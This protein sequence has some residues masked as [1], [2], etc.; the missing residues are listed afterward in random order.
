[1]Q[2]RLFLKH[3]VYTAGTLASLPLLHACGAGTS[4]AITPGNSYEQAHL[5]ASALT[6]VALLRPTTVD[7]LCVRYS[8]QWRRFPLDIVREHVA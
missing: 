2:R 1:M 3:G 7:K 4:E 6:K 5:A 8:A